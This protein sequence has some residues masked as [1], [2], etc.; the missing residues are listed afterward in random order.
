MNKTTNPG[1]RPTNPSEISFA[2][3]CFV[4]TGT[5]TEFSVS[6]SALH[7]GPMKF[8]TDRTAAEEYARKTG[9]AVCESVVPVRARVSWR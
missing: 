2:A 8:G 7:P 1:P 3:H 9:R 4:Q 5:R 6:R